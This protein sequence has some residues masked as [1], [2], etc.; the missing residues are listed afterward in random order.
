MICMFLHGA[1]SG[2]PRAGVEQYYYSG[3]GPSSSLVSRLH[4]EDHRGWYGEARYNYD[5]EQTLSFNAGRTF[6]REG[7]L[8]YSFTPMA[9]VLVGKTRAVSSGINMTMDRKDICFSSELQYVFSAAD[10]GGNFLYSWSELG[11]QATGYLYTGIA[12]QQLSPCGG[13]IKWEPGIQVSIS[14]KKWRFPVYFF[15]PSRA[16]RYFVLGISYDWEFAKRHL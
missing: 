15:N 7:T 16:G 10:G 13:R 12:L 8:S 3:C 4:F 11:Y 6:A 1:A 2:Q 9:G 5:A 14:C